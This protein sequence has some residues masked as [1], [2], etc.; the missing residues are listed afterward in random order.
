[1]ALLVLAFAGS[2]QACSCA[3]MRPADH[4]RSADAAIVGRLVAVVPRG[5]FRADYR[6][7]VKR[8]YRGGDEI[9]RGETLAVGSARRAAACALP[10][11][12]GRMYGLFLARAGNGW[13]SG[14][15]GVI[16][17]RRLRTALRR[18]R[19]RRRSAA[20]SLNCDS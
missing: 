1:V 4:L 12:T 9:E 18:S 3:P 14:I 2:A 17:P 6:Y 13:A 19:D 10:R 11:R 20:G 8:V 15:C 5:P 7:R 16:S